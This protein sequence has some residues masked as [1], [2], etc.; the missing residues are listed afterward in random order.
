LDQRLNEL[1]GQSLGRIERWLLGAIVRV[2]FMVGDER[3][4]GFRL[5]HDLPPYF[6]D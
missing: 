2:H 4:I 5:L 6:N 1:D 3:M